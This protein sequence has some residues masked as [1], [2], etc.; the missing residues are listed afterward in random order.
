M[1]VRL[2]L[3]H[4]LTEVETEV[5]DFQ[6][7]WNPAII[8]FQQ[9][10]GVEVP[11]LQELFSVM[12]VMAVELQGALQEL[13]V[14]AA[15]V[16]QEVAPNGGPSG[17]TGGTG[18]RSGF[19]GSASFGGNGGNGGHGGSGPLVQNSDFA[20]GG[21]GGGYGTGGGSGGTDSTAIIYAGNGGFGGG[22]GGGAGATGSGNNRLS[23]GG[24]GGGGFNGGSGGNVPDTAICT[25]S[26]GGGG[27]GG[28]C[29]YDNT[30]TTVLS[31]TNGGGAQAGMNGSLTISWST[32][33][34]SAS[35]TS[36]MVTID[37]VS[38]PPD[39]TVIYPVSI[40]PGNSSM[41]YVAG[42]ITGTAANWKWYSGSCGGSL[43][44]TGDTVYLSPLS[45]TI[46]WVRAEG[47]CNTT[48]C[49]SITLM[50]SSYS[51][52]PVSALSVTPICSGSGTTLGVSGGVLGTW[53]DWQW[54]TGSCGSTPV[55]TGL[56]PV[57][58]PTLNSTYY[59]RAEGQCNTTIC[60]STTV[61]V[62]PIIGSC[63]FYCF[64]HS[65]LFR[66]PCQPF[67]ERRFFRLRCGLDMVRRQLRR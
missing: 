11:G 33:C 56:S 32:G 55:A 39:S 46:Y 7:C 49:S 18:Y 17:G 21:G 20:G 57:L 24:G 58:N 6:E 36:V 52:T 8:L 22:G 19:N 47:K 61:D 27:G 44:A 4:I 54:Y 60:V 28:S 65:G 35:R 9:G 10:V 50:I 15:T 53:A 14:V 51:V 25:S 29:Y 43:E 2:V 63:K 31:N 3:I 1:Q 13:M 62:Y 5:E 38:V 30:R 66:Q 67:K 45:A 34:S 40:C 26:G 16:E 59:V 37:S 64:L 42:G 23:G 12:E 41:F 48:V